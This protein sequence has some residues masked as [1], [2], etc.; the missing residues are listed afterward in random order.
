MNRIDKPIRSDHEFT[1]S[2]TKS[3]IIWRLVSVLFTVII[4]G[5][6]IV[7]LNALKRP[8]LITVIDSSSGKTYTSMSESR[9]S[10]TIVERQLIYYS[11]VFCESFLS[12]N[13][14]TVINDRKEA[15]DLMHPELEVQLPEDFAKRKGVAE[16]ISSKSSTT[17]DW[18]I[19]PVVSSAADPYYTVFC[20][21]TK[22]TKK[23]GY[24]AFSQ[25]YNI[26]LDWGRLINNTD[27]FNRPHD[28]VL[29]KFE[30]LDDNSAELK[31]QLNLIR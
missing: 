20:Q 7:T 8:R 19:K 28:L 11:K 29:I 3:I 9:M 22:R 25:K 12:E 30:E 1:A 16:I 31:H 21:F 17:F 5:S 6:F 14:V 13:Y 4:V 10:K 27:P 24:K 26:K 15:I 18:T 2:L 23:Q